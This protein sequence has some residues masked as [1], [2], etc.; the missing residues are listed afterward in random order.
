M[1]EIFVL[2]LFL[3]PAQFTEC[4]HNQLVPAK[5][6]YFEQFGACEEMGKTLVDLDEYDD[7]ACRRHEQ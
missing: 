6:I 5:T 7:H 2:T 4:T 3:C 1:T